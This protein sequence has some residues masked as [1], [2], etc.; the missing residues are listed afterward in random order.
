MLLW[1]NPVACCFASVAFHLLT[2]SLAY[3]VP[4]P[5]HSFLRELHAGP[6][7][8]AQPR[9]FSASSLPGFPLPCACPQAPLSELARGPALTAPAETH[10][11]PPGAKCCLFSPDRPFTKRS[12]SVY[13]V[14]TAFFPTCMLYSVCLLFASPT[15]KRVVVP[16]DV[17]AAGVVPLFRQLNAAQGGPWR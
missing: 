16:W 3:L 6:T 15:F 5:S 11:V 17:L 7:V 4:C 14:S 12:L 2:L 8:C 10:S 1:I 9:Q 13:S